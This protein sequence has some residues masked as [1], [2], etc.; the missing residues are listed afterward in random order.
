MPNFKQITRNYTELYKTLY[1]APSRRPENYR[2]D[3]KGVF[4][5][6]H[7]RTS[8]FSKNLS[9]EEIKNRFET[10]FFSD[11]KNDYTQGCLEGG[12]LKI[13]TSE[14][15]ESMIPYIS[16]RNLY[17][18]DVI[19][20]IRVCYV[21][22]ENVLCA[23]SIQIFKDLKTEAPNVF[24]YAI[25]VY[26]NITNQSAEGNV[27]YIADSRLLNTSLVNEKDA[28]DISSD[29]VL[30]RLAQA[31][32]SD[33]LLDAIAPIIAGKDYASKPAFDK[34][35]KCLLNN[36]NGYAKV[37]ELG[38]YNDQLT[39]IGSPEKDAM[40][41]QSYFQRHRSMILS[42]A[43]SVLIG[44][45]AIAAMIFVVPLVIGI[46]VVVLSVVAARLAQVECRRDEQLL[47]SYK[48]RRDVAMSKITDQYER[49]LAA[50]NS[51]SES[52]RPQQ[53]GFFL[54]IISSQPASE[55]MGEVFTR[56][57]KNQ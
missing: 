6:D 32:K 37:L 43:V 4:N 26:Q 46:P 50:M 55:E 38:N 31:L 47:Q 42:L 36:M 8:Y 20:Q 54:P 10:E 44:I 45:S 3:S 21:N 35:N 48:I 1:T 40:L 7:D 22:D 34:L 18:R 56:D 39:K 23:F 53:P 17:T 49:D 9:V 16:E 14:H 30:G 33:V 24:H 15:Y 28:D 52:I 13:H 11:D 19:D 29:Q 25:A 12:L 2:D 27:T 51:S 41:N 5:R 57:K